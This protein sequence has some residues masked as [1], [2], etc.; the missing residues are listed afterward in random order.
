[1][2][3]PLRAVPHRHERL[4][5]R[6]RV[7]PGRG[8]P[9]RAASPSSAAAG[10]GSGGDDFPWKSLSVPVYSLATAG[11]DDDDEAAGA[12]PATMNIVTYCSAVSIRPVRK[13]ALGLYVGTLSW[14]NFLREGRGVLQVLNASHAGA[15]ELLGT[16]S[17]RDVDK[18][19]ALGDAGL[20]LADWRGVRILKG[21]A[22]GLLLERAADAPADPIPCGDHDVVIADVVDIFVG[23]RESP[24]L[25]T[26]QLR[27]L[28]II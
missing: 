4:P 11:T 22:A 20:E 14:E 12:A 17:G 3:G 16:R 28:G 7:G 27:D 2:G 15:V 5:C 13:Y 25:S 9:R 1:M 8:R 6:D 26:G 18:L 24:L 21:C 23:D 10:G 19:A